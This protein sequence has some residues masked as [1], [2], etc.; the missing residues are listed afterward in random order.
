MGTFSCCGR[1][2]L[3]FSRMSVR[4]C[5]FWKKWWVMGQHLVTHDPCDPSDF[6]DPFDP[7]PMT[8]RPIPC[9]ELRYSMLDLYCCRFGRQCPLCG[10]WASSVSDHGLLPYFTSRRDICCSAR[11]T[12]RLVRHWRGVDRQRF[13]NAIKN[14][15]LA[16]PPFSATAKELFDLYHRVLSRFCLADRFAPVHRVCCHY[17]PLTP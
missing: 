7:W 12:S 13:A 5:Y 11:H 16:L 17:R 14:S 10:G 3:G 9:S 8:H 15:E 6:R 2:A 1:S 4:L